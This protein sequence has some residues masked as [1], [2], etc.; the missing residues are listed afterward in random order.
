MKSMLALLALMFIASA[1]ISDSAVAQQ[2][3]SADK[4]VT[5]TYISAE[6]IQAGFQA[7]SNDGGNVRVV[8]AAGYNVAVG[9]IRRVKN[10]NAAVHFNVTEVYHVTDGAATL[11]TG[12]TMVDPVTRP[13]A[14]RGIKLEDGPSASGTSI[15]GG[16]SQRIKA[17]DVVIIPANVAH[18]FSNIEGSLSYVVVRYDPDRFLTVK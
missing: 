14:A 4:N 18:Y 3:A 15:K 13:P 12:G 17:G 1:S 9:A 6:D 16:V 8:N 10:G 7:N 2:G 11:V 5:A